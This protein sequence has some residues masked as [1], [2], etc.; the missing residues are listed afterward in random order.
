[1][2][3]CELYTPLC[4]VMYLFDRIV[5][6]L[7]LEMTVNVVYVYTHKVCMYRL[8]IRHVCWACHRSTRGVGRK[9]RCFDKLIAK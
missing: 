5:L 8:L 9:E 4:H 6:V 2:L 3:K 7:D 1:M